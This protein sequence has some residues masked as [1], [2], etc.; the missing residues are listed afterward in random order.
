MI[1]VLKIFFL[2]LTY[3]DNKAPEH[4]RIDLLQ[5]FNIRFFLWNHFASWFFQRNKCLIQW[6]IINTTARCQKSP[7][8]ISCH[9][10]AN[11]F[12]FYECE[13]CSMLEASGVQ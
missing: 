13:L 4:N 2:Y 1:P 8:V 12:F 11:C 6:Q 9:S 7:F 5:A 3:R 10:V